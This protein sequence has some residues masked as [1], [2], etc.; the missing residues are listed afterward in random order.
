MTYIDFLTDHLT[1]DTVLPP[2][3]EVSLPVLAYMHQHSTQE[4]VL[5]IFLLR[6][7]AQV[8]QGRGKTSLD[9]SVQDVADVLG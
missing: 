1:R 5:E 7:H 9:E 2:V 3:E 8:I 4:P 6:S